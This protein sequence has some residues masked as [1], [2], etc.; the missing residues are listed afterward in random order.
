MFVFSCTTHLES[1]SK[2]PSKSSKKPLPDV[3]FS[4]DGASDVGVWS[5]VAW[6]T[7]ELVADEIAAKNSAKI[8]I[9][10]S[11]FFKPITTNAAFLTVVEN[12]GG[13]F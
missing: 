9:A 2:A 5:T 10:D 7:A 8:T 13:A 11:S 1:L 6:A 12:D 3:G 4:A